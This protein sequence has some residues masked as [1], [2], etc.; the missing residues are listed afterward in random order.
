MKSAV[1]ES[2]L[3]STNFHENSS[4][5]CTTSVNLPRQFSYVI[6]ALTLT[7]SLLNYTLIPWKESRYWSPQAL[8][9]DYSSFL[10]CSGWCSITWGM[11]GGLSFWS[12]CVGMAT[13]SLFMTSDVFLLFIFISTL[14]ARSWSEAS[15]LTVITP[16]SVTVLIGRRVITPTET[17]RSLSRCSF[18]VH[19]KKIQ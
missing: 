9:I 10:R 11:Q 4:I 18:F 12:L 1:T 19:T 14:W 17:A 16:S 3:S 8:G 6:N 5:F 2:I 13:W 15:F 7:I